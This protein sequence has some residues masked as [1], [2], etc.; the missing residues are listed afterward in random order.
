MRNY[1]GNFINTTSREKKRDW[2]LI[3]LLF[4]F[5]LWSGTTTIIGAR[6]ILPDGLAW[7]SGITVQ[8]MLFFLLSGWIMK[9][10]IFRKWLAILI[11]T[12][13]SIYTS[14]FCYYDI[15]T[16]EISQTRAEIIAVDAHQSLISSVFTPLERQAIKLEKEL[17]ELQ[18]LARREENEGLTTGQTGCGEKCRQFKQQATSKK[19][20]LEEFNK[21]VADLRPKFEYDITGLKANEIYKKD[22]EALASVE[23]SFRNGYELKYDNYIDVEREVSFIAPY[24]K[25]FKAGSRETIAVFALLIALSIDGIAIIQGTAIE[26]RKKNNSFIKIMTSRLVELIR[27]TKYAVREIVNV[28]NNEEQ[29]DE[30]D[31]QKIINDIH[32]KSEGKGDQILGIFLNSIDDFFPYSLDSRIFENYQDLLLHKG[33][34]DLRSQLSKMGFLTVQKNFSEEEWLVKEESVSNLKYL[35]KNEINR[36]SNQN[37]RKS[38]KER[39]KDHRVSE[40]YYSEDKDDTQ[41]DWSNVFDNLKNRNKKH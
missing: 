16:A 3:V 38:S 33:L 7:L 30:Q 31:I 21:L 5:N 13:V 10:S 24:Y 2:L 37:H 4:F 1:Y 41:Q 35:L 9:D 40:Y 39:K 34:I 26:A 29:F 17:N 12:T 6:Q 20:E 27:S 32:I 15:L 36:L 19:A 14:F 23:E 22:R 28:V 8:V 11:F 18:E 25:V